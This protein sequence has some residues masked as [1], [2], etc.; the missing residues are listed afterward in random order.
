MCRLFGLSAGA[1]PVHAT[2]WLLDARDSLARQSRREPD[3]T[4]LGYFDAD[5]SPRVDKEPIAAWRDAAFATE[6]K[7]VESSTFV[8]HV[9]FA[10][11]TP[12]TV[13]NTHPFEQQGRLFAHN[14]VIG[15]SARL[16]QELGAERELVGGET[17]SE[18][19]FALITREIDAHG[20]DIGAGIVA[21]SSWVA[22]HLPVLSLNLVLVT[23]TDLWAL[24]YPDAHELHVLERPA[25]G[26]SGASAL[27]HASAAGTLRARCGDLAARPA[28]V[29]ASEPMDEDASWRLLGS[30]ELIH[31]DRTL[32]LTS[33]TVLTQ[34]PAHPLTLA[35]LDPGAV[36]SQRGS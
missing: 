16:E 4:G 21:A 6:A 15:D 14:G 17:D 35:Q 2:F 20:G 26:R 27:Q 12:L 36:A 11:G 3:G 5:G 30:G 13:E 19:F 10:S 7:E 29:I 22:A 1:Q 34:P 18:R 32:A 31:V 23:A 24:R 8:G 25:G 33:A 9:R 28:V